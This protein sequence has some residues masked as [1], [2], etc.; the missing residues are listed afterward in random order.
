ML[1]FD[2][3]SVEQNYDFVR[4]REPTQTIVCVHPEDVAW[5]VLLHGCVGGQRLVCG[6]V[7]AWCSTL[8]D[9]CLL[10]LKL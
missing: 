3:L 9:P 7:N 2:S 8:S 4:V 1:T 5:R 6:F 10:L